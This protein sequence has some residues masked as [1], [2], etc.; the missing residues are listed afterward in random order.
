MNLSTPILDASKVAGN[1]PALCFGREN[2]TVGNPHRAQILQFELFE[3]YPL[4]EKHQ[5]SQKTEA[6]I[7]EGRH[8]VNFVPLRF[9]I[10]TKHQQSQK[11]EA[12]IREM[13]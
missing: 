10:I 12:A 13:L 4:I 3:L 1:I 5:Q 9:D 6:A 7:R 11:T 2:D 8:E